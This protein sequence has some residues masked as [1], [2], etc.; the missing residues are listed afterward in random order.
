MTE[1]TYKIGDEVLDRLSGR[2]M[3]VHDIKQGPNGRMIAVCEHRGDDGRE[4]VVEDFHFYA[5]APYVGMRF[6]P[7]MK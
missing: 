4:R 5:I 1:N 7:V 6:I 2:K 3:I